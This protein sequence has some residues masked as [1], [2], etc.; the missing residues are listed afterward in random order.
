MGTR[1]LQQATTQ[2][3]TYS[4]DD[5][6]AGLRTV[7]LTVSDG[8]LID[9]Q[10][11]YVT[12]NNVGGPPYTLV[13]NVVGGGSV[14]KSPDQA[15]Y[16]EGTVVTLTATPN[17][18]WTFAGWSGDASGSVSPTTVTMNGNKAVTATFTA[19]QYTITV[20]VVGSGS[21]AKTPNQATYAYGTVVTLT[22]SPVSGWSFSGWSGDASGNTNPTSITVTGDMTVAATFTQDQYSLVVT[23]VGGGSVVKNPDQATYTYNTVVTLTAQ[24]T[25]GWSFAGWS[26]DASGTTNP[27]TVAIT[28]NKIVT[29]T[30][31]PQYNLLIETRGSGSTNPAPGTYTYMEGA[32]VQVDALPASGYKL[33]YWLL[34]GTS[35]GAT[36][37]YTVTVS[38][39]RNLTAV[40]VAAPTSVFEDGFESGSTSAW[41]SSS[42]TSGE[43]VAVGTDYAHHGIY[44]AKFTGNG[45][46]GYES[47]R[48]NRAFSPSLS[49]IY[50]R[51]YFKLT[52]NG[53]VDNGDKVKLMELR[54]GSTIVASA[55]L[56]RSSGTLRWWLETRSGTSWVETYTSQIGSLDLTQWFSVELY[57]KLGAT[58]GA[59]KLWV[60]GNQIYQITNADTDNYGSIS[61]LRFGLAELTNCASTTLYADCAVVA[62]A[63]IGPEGLSAQYTLNVEVQSLPTPSAT[64]ARAA[65][66]H[67]RKFA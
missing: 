62:T 11:W 16:S 21:V 51:G 61:T 25:S 33:D 32:T 63:Y 9:S 54:A 20:S 17:L 23:V 42:I 3:W 35:V 41:S 56:W 7:K 34:N 1:L 26:G 27:N 57:W 40:F 48:L 52:Q 8:S 5:T 64:P 22:A 36:D 6:S 47:A 30:F 13:V 19:P 2:N 12:V 39:N 49:E 60:N 50:V 44:S 14:T 66:Q 46:G 53:I 15:N 43:T 29:A 24:P 31:L 59:A 65:T 28:S 55:G 10:E 45:G 37:P 4:P 58:D 18:G 67:S 38:G